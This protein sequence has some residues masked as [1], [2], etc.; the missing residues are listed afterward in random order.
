MQVG[1]ES[2]EK[3]MEWWSEECVRVVKGIQK[4]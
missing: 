2:G 4:A 1:G 3:I